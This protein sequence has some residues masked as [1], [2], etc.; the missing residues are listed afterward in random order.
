MLAGV[1]F[2]AA[3]RAWR[4][5]AAGC[6]DF[7]PSASRITSASSR[8]PS[9]RARAC[10]LVSVFGV[11]GCSTLRGAA[12]AYPRAV[13]RR[14]ASR[15]KW[16]ARSVSRYGTASCRQCARGVVLAGVWFC[17]AVCAWRGRAAGC[18]GFAPSASRI[19]S[20]SSRPPSA[21]ARACRLVSGLGVVG[22]GTLRGAAA[23]YPRAVG[24]R[25]ASGVKQTMP[26]NKIIDG[27]A[28]ETVAEDI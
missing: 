11:V 28:H 14:I 6:I 20:A 27:G 5:R 21:R 26:G 24:Q 17:A 22:C 13:M 12:A 15:T 10:N 8:P 2:C 4:G 19:T 3:V 9:A 18:I 16:C 23:A 25:S 7:A 1:W